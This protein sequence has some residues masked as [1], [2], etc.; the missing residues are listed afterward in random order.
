MWRIAVKVMGLVILFKRV[1]YG[2]VGVTAGS[3]LRLSPYPLSLPSVISDHHYML[4][5][6]NYGYLNLRLWKTAAR[7]CVLYDTVAAS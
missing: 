5:I 6:W 1:A 3:L 7:L 4:F 2:W